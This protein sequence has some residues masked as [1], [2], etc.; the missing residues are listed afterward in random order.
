ME[1][2]TREGAALRRRIAPRGPVDMDAVAGM[3]GA[4]LGDW[5]ENRW[6]E[7]WLRGQTASDEAAPAE[8]RRWIAAHAIGHHLL[9]GDDDRW[10]GRHREMGADAE[11]EAEGFAWALLVDEQE[12]ETMRFREPWQVAAFFGVPEQAVRDH[13]DMPRLE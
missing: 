2:A 12:A 6:V 4:E 5:T 9:H 7:R 1:L 10:R 11:R 13:W 3:V 8:W